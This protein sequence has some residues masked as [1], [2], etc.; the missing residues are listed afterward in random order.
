MFSL[1]KV[2]FI[3]SPRFDVK[4]KASKRGVFISLSLMGRITTYR[5]PRSKLVP[6]IR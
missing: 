5:I 1:F 6:T 4:Q 3:E 2:I